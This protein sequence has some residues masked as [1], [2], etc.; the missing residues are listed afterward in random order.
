MR[1]RLRGGSPSRRL[2]CVVLFAQSVV[3][4]RSRTSHGYVQLQLSA[5]R[6]AISGRDCEKGMR[7]GEESG[8][9]RTWKQSKDEVGIERVRAQ[10]GS[11]N[12][13]GSA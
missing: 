13:C 12:A 4:R 3:C 2:V 8:R 6:N 10:E 11:V 1:A 7:R 9:E 5:F